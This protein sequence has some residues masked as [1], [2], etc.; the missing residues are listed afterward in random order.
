MCERAGSLCGQLRLSPQWRD[1]I[2]HSSELSRPQG[3]EA[4]VR[5]HQLPPFTGSG[6][7]RSELPCTFVTYRVGLC[8]RERLGLIIMTA[9]WELESKGM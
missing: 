8:S 3:E 6:L 5:I 9:V 4:G 1:G 7:L 2:G